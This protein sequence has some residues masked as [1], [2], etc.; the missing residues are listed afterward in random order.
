[1]VSVLQ[2]LRF[3][4]FRSEL[5]HFVTFLGLTKGRLVNDLN[6]TTNL[7]NGGENRKE[8]N[9]KSP[10]ADLGGGNEIFADS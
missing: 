1:M 7:V 4:K 2:F 10:V 9:R 3:L 6:V 8:R 5:F